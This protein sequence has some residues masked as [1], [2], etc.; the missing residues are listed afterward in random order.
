[1]E[2]RYQVVDDS[3]TSIVVVFNTEEEANSFVEKQEDKENL[4]VVPVE[5]ID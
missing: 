1:M 4:R 3:T 2:T 5:V